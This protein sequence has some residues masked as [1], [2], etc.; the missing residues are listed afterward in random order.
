MKIRFSKLDPV[1]KTFTALA[2]ARA[3]EIDHTLTLNDTLDK[4]FKFPLSPVL[5]KLTLEQIAT[6]S[7]GLEKVPNNFK[8]SRRAKP[9]R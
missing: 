3:M 4:L 9:V 5:A 2:F 1:S 8:T 7:S 6:Q